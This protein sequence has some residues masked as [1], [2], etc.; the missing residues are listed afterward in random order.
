MQSQLP[1]PNKKAE[2]KSVVRFIGVLFCFC[3]KN[4][5]FAVSSS[6]NEMLALTITIVA[7]AVKSRP[8]LMSSARYE[9]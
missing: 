9:T 5:R 7:D 6:D 2:K 8:V 4:K 1:D 3:Q